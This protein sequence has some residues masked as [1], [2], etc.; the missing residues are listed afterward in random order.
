[1]KS[2]THLLASAIFPLFCVGSAA[3]QIVNPS[4]EQG[5]AG[6]NVNPGVFVVGQSVS[7]PIGVDGSYSADLGGGGI[8][9][10]QMS[11]TVNVLL[12]AN[13]ELR[14][15]SAANGSGVPGLTSVGK[16]EIL[17]TN[18]T[19]LASLTF[20]NVSPASML[21]TNGFSPVVVP[22]VT[23]ANETVVTVRF[24]DETPNGGGGVDVAIDAAQLSLIAARNR[25]AM[26]L[27]AGVQISGPE[28]GTYEI[29]Y[30]E[31]LGGQTSTNW[32]SLTN[33]SLSTFPHVFLDA[34][35]PVRGNARR[36]Y[37]SVY[38]P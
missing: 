27:Y 37:R 35:G 8:A 5:L 10:S 29:Q 25:L 21:G 3:A 14:F 1:M 17:S 16:V 20:T 34:S 19:A 32:L 15:F 23:G 7:Q 11:Q 28:P 18:G 6:W 2:I 9:G 30:V 24:S 4:F 13:Y 22:F 33:L 31:S 12:D 36:F 26:E 38:K